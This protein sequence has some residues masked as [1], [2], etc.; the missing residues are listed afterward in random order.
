MQE[1]IRNENDLQTARLDKDYHLN[2]IGKVL[3]YQ[4]K[5]TKPNAINQPC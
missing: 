1:A 4:S 5:V 3:H 2:L